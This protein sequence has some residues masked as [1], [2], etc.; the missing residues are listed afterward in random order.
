MDGCLPAQ[1]SYDRPPVN[2]GSISRKL[3]Y[4]RSSPPVL[5]IGAAGD[6]KV[7]SD[8]TE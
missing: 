6:G 8:V 4:A 5:Y 2:P 1:A 3:F 7:R